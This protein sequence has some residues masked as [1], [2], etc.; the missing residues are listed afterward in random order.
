MG[1]KINR[2]LLN[3]DFMKVL[4]EVNQDFLEKYE[5]L[6]TNEFQCCLK[7]LS[8]YMPSF[9]FHIRLTQEGD[10]FIIENVPDSKLKGM[11]QLD[12]CNTVIVGA[13]LGADFVLFE[14][15]VTLANE[16]PDLIDKGLK[17]IKKNM[18]ARIKVFIDSL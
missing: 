13:P 2:R 17:K 12:V 16:L 4:C 11:V 6:A 9:F 8:A 15:D 14:G 3:K 5:E 18:V 10:N 7:P 1:F